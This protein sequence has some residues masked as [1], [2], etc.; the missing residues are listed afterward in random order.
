MTEP[1][2]RSPLEIVA[3]L[4]VEERASL[5]SGLDFWHT[6]PVAREN[7]PSIML[8]DG[9]HGVRKQ[10]AE[11]DHLGLHSSV[12]ATCFPPAVALGCSFDPE[13]L[14]RVGAAL[15]AE[16]RALQVGVL[17]GPG[18][19]IK[20]SPLCGRNFEY[21]SE[22][23]LLSGVLGAA[24]VHGMQSQG[25]GASL[26]HF[27]ANNQETD[28]MRVSAD[29]DPRPLREI[30]LRAFER[31]VRDAQPWTVMC[32]YNRI[33]GVYS[34]R[35]PWLLTDVLRGE[36]GFEGLVV[37]DWGAVDD[38]VASLAAGLD[39]EMPSTGGRTD[40]EIVAAVRAGTVD[41][42]VLD[43]AAARV[44]ELVQKAVAASDPGATFDAD[45]HHALA[46]EVAAQSIVLL[47]NENDL[48]PLATDANIAVIGELARTPRYQGAGSSRIEPTRL[49]NA[50]DE[51]RS[52]SGRDVPFAAGYALDGSDSAELVDEAVKRA[53]D[54]DIAVVFLGVP[55]ELESEG[56]DRDDLELPQR[57]TALLDAVLTANPNVVVVLSNGGVVRLSGFADRV[58][59]I[60]EGWLLGQAGGG[61]V[62]DVLYGHA[63]PSGRLAETVPIRL[64]DTPA[65][66]NFPGEHG[67][68]RYGE[69][70]FVGY[71][72]YDARRLD[73]SFPFGHGL[74]YTTFE[75]SDAAVESD[76]D[77]TVHVTVT[78]TGG[79]A[80][81]EVVQVYAGAPGSS[82]ARAPREL[83][84]FTKVR[85]DSGES[86]R[87]AVSIRRDDLAYWD[88]RVDSWVVEGGTY[89]IDIGAS[90][91]DIRQ[92]LTVDMTG[93][94]VRIP[95]T[96][97]SSLGE[98]FQNPAAAE[99][100]LQAF[101][102]LG[103]EV[104]VDESVLKMAASMPLGRLAG[105]APGVESEQIQQLL[106]VVNQQ[107]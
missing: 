12:P 38:R 32:S 57:Q 105:F 55:A 11:G 13:L 60:V 91:R 99:I 35:N 65:H 89:S 94:A 16:A 42:S 23:P 71:R 1:A 106:D 20:R 26:K 77:L 53:A 41:E 33:N 97:E 74:S 45:A 43:T 44:T 39:L 88:T 107:E 4:T 75:Y 72:S 56:F 96:M 27:A 103:G 58:P 8:T 61:A 29:V 52:L 101:G 81:A 46:R 54:A 31:V 102:S 19:N 25:V 14:E 82:V 100:V 62:A 18:I 9:P 80:G 93:D 2:L 98:L 90:S 83:K 64:E 87:V 6:E 63:N 24:L 79:R 51:I 50:L 21:L 95:L 30:Y 86:Q 36:W 78:N 48:L 40:A 70:L 69:G 84:G 34:S 22:D 10:T 67:H 104:G 28:R 7:I 85:L 76:G 73:V 68:V 59:A 3:R 92:T 49:D 37:S 17:L 15:G 5:T 66:T 47:R